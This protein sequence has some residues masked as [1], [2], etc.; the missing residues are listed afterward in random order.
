LK[1]HQRELDAKQTISESET[2][3]SE[4]IQYQT[5]SFER[6]GGL[7][8]P[9]G[10]SKSLETSIID[11]SLNVHGGWNLGGCHAHGSWMAHA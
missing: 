3:K 1:V 11:A 8:R 10:T 2:S 5:M 7:A 9:V 6:L 4:H